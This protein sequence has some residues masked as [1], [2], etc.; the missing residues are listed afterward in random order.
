VGFDAGVGKPPDV[1]RAG[2]DAEYLVA[3]AV[4]RKRRGDP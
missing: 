2:V 1:R 3:S 4:Q